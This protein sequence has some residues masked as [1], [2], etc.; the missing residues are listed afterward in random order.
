M[1]SFL[2]HLLIGIGFVGISIWWAF[3][4]SFRYIKANKPNAKLINYVYAGSVPMPCYCCPTKRLRSM[5]LE[6]ILKTLILTM[7]IILELS[8]GSTLF[9]FHPGPYFIASD[10]LQHI[11]MSGGFLVSSM[12]E[13]LIHYN[14]PL[15]KK[16][17]YIINLVAGMVFA[18]GVS[19]HLDDR[20]MMD[21][22]IHKILAILVV[23]LLIAYCYEIYDSD[24]F[25]A[26]YGRIYFFCMFGSWLIEI[27]FIKWPV[28]AHPYFH[29]G[30]NMR[31]VMVIS[32]TLGLHFISNAL[33]FIFLHILIHR[34]F[35]CLNRIFKENEK[36]DESNLKFDKNFEQYSMII[37]EPD[38][39]LD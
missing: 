11:I 15:P 35:P 30:S 6:S 36:Y 2:G 28:S 22:H 32:S 29:W 27:A 19:M 34:L 12:F 20:D 8:T 7:H 18:V 39:A 31:D 33:F 37:E 14:L 21:Y 9:S 5:P 26:T 16:S 17:V 10:T 24:N 23:L 25:W 13:V 3:I 38:D 4:T 1:G